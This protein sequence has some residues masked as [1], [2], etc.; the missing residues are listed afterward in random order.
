MLIL[1]YKCLTSQT[2]V[3]I[4]LQ[5]AKAEGDGNFEVYDGSNMATTL[6]RDFYRPASQR[7]F[8]NGRDHTF[9]VCMG[10]CAGC[11]N[12]LRGMYNL[13]SWKG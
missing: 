8:G 7:Q 2:S 4:L 3:A 10:N 5:H 13:E 1:S 6:K 11:C 9:T 12:S